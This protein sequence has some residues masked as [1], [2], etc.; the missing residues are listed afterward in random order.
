MRTTRAVS[1]ARI[2]L[3]RERWEHIRSRHPELER[4]Q[5]RVLETVGR[6]DLVQRGDSGELLAIR[7][8]ET[9]PLTEKYLVVPYREVGQED[10]FV[11]TAYFTNQPA[12]W[13][14]VVWKP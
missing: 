13:R 11:L 5:S 10:G 3:T 7:H 8:Y 9:T 2:R 12:R 1:G 4:Q 6:P 14:E